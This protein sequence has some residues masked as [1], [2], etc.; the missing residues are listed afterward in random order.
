MNNIH[1]NKIIHS[2]QGFGLFEEAEINI[3][4]TQLICNI[5]GYETTIK[6]NFKKHKLTHNKIVKDKVYDCDKC[7]FCVSP[8]CFYG[9]LF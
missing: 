2:S 3:K 6:T 4:L 1:I 9:L 5:C 8:P 7:L